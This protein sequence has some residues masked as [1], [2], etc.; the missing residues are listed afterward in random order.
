MQADD[1]RALLAEHGGEPLLVFGFTFMVWLYLSGAPSPALD[2]SQAVLVH[3]GG[4]KKLAEQAV[5][6]ADVHGR[7]C[8]R[9][10]GF[11][12]CTTSTGWSSRS[13]PSSSSASRAS[14]TR[15]TS[16]TSSSATR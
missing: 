15:R 5:D 14:S 9:P 10:P 1:V 12:A 4:W 7:A 3:S 2:L 13:A 8:A 6:N 16:P 11:G